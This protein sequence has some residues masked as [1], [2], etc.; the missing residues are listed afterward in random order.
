MYVCINFLELNANF[1]EDICHTFFLAIT[2]TSY[3]S[4]EVPQAVVNYSFTFVYSNIFLINLSTLY[5]FTNCLKLH[6]VIIRSNT[7]LIRFLL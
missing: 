4:T 1:T 5:K 3:E 2:H 7:V 6:L